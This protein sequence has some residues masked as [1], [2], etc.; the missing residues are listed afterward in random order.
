PRSDA[1]TSHVI[2]PLALPDALPIFGPSGAEDQ[3][4]AAVIDLVKPL[5]HEVTVDAVGSV[6]ALRR[7]TGG[8]GTK[9]V[10]IAAHM[11]EIGIMVTDRKSTRLNSSHVESSYAVFCL[12]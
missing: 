2:H 11:D 7:G 5:A 1:L 10:M 6:I 12:K 9:K 8:A 3:V 4:R